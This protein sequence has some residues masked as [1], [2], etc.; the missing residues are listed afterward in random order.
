MELFFAK[1]PAA[2]AGAGAGPLLQDVCRTPDQE[3]ASCASALSGFTLPAGNTWAAAG[4]AMK[5]ATDHQNAQPPAAQDRKQVKMDVKRTEFGVNTPP[6]PK[7]KQI[8]A[9]YTNS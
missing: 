1:I 8:L 5:Q 3:G 6:F 4:A 2:G 7:Q 9:A